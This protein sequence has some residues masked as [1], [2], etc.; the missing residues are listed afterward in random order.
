MKRIEALLEEC[1]DL[2]IR[3]LKDE[4]KELQVGEHSII[5]L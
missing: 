5:T 1:R 2:P 4:M 3:K